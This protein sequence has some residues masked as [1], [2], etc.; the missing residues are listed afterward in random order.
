MGAQVGMVDGD[1]GSR[2]P[3]PVRRLAF[4]E[5]IAPDAAEPRRRGRAAFPAAD[6]SDV[7][8]MPGAAMPPPGARADLTAVPPDV[9]IVDRMPPGPLLAANAV[10]WRRMGSGVVFAGTRP[11]ALPA[12]A[13]A[14]EAA[15]GGRA[16][17]ARFAPASEADVARALERVAPRQAEAAEVRTPGPDSC[18][19]LGARRS[20]AGA[21]AALAAF[22]TATLLAPMTVLAVASVITALFVLAG[23]TL[24]AAALFSAG[25]KRPPR[26]PV[27]H[28]LPVISVMVPLFRE[29]AIAERLLVRLSRIDYPRHLLDVRL[30]T[31]AEDHTT[32][33]ALAA[34][35]LPR[36]TTVVTVPDG[37]IRTK[38]RALNYALD[39]CR[40]DIIGIWD[41][42]DAP[43]PDQLL[44]VAAE[45][46][47]APPGVA[48]LQGRLAFATRGQ[49]WL[50]RCFALEYAGWFRIILPGFEAL[51]LPIPLGGTTVFLRRGPLEA[52]GAW[53]AHN[54]TE[55]A[56]LGIRLARRG[57]RTALIDTVTME[58]P[59]TRPIAWIRQR[60]RWLKGYAVTWMVHSRRPRRLV[61]DL[62]PWGALGVQVVLL[63]TLVQFALAPALWLYWIGLPGGGGAAMALGWTLAGLLLLSEAVNWTVAVLGAK[64]AGIMRHAVLVPT[65]LLYFP[66]AT[67]AAWKALVEVAVAP[68]YWD[69]T[70]H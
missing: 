40:G 5:R 12:L 8:R 70:A 51:G 18:R 26:R 42:E 21:S 22:A 45:F 39:G 7:I 30:V 46:A 23:T 34:A 56:D 67:L 16:S 66:L 19:W 15:G 59:N 10:P 57:W 36:W 41:A 69:K 3:S 6:E 1:A 55:D 4:A 2:P 17:G 25:W 24:R 49:G 52:V 61:R 31:E 37:P 32:R 35:D 11:E 68:F 33:R 47:A 63:G 53:D 28:D 58:E 50:A 65:M 62:G 64:R 48:C 29:A 20:G 54:V 44:R 9:R 13:A 38:P 14:W 60:S 43:A 27:P